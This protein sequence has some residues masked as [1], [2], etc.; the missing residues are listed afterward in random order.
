MNNSEYNEFYPQ[1]A[2]K[3]ITLAET[4]TAKS[5]NEDYYF[6]QWVKSHPYDTYEDYIEKL[7][8]AMNGGF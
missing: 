6:Q 7:H 1:L 5:N 8:D 3:G 4:R 2:Q